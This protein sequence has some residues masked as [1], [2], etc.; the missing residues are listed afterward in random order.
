M[1]ILVLLICFHL[2]SLRLHNY[3][4][5]KE[6]RAHRAPKLQIISISKWPNG[7]MLMPEQLACETLAIGELVVDRSSTL[8]C[9]CLSVC[10]NLI[11]MNNFAHE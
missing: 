5:C 3:T 8:V 9:I 1:L 2:L 11:I 6:T 7:Q 10:E 4:Y